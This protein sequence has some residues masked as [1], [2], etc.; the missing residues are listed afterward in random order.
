LRYKSLIYLSLFIVL[1]LLEACD[2]NN[3]SNPVAPPD[4]SNSIFPLRVG[5]RW[6]VQTTNYDTTGAVVY[7]QED[8]IRIL[9]DTTIQNERWYVG[10]GI[11]TN[12]VDGLYDY[13]PGSSSP[14]SLKFKYPVSAPFSYLY[15]GVTAKV[16]STTDTVSVQAGTF[17]C[18]L[19]RTGIDS[20][21]YFDDYYSTGVGL[22]KRE[23]FNPLAAGG[24]YKYLEY[25]LKAYQLQ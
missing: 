3:V 12:R 18:H 15:R 10:Y 23:S 19:Y 1:F 24:V 11:L 25:E 9:R 4:P 16:L 8:S 13:Q 21:S 2:K 17:I 22:I 7:T 14:A 20:V 5:N 6:T